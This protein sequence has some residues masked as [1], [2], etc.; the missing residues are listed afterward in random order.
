MKKFLTVLC[1]A[2]LLTLVCGSAL[3]ASTLDSKYLHNTVVIN[4]LTTVNGKTVDTGTPDYIITVE[5]KCVTGTVK[6]KMT[7]GTYE[8][9]SID[10]I[11]NWG[12]KAKDGKDAS[13]EVGG[14]GQYVCKDCGAVKEGEVTIPATGHKFD[15]KV[16]DNAETCSKDG[17]YHMECSY[18]GQAEL[19]S[20]KSGIKYTA[21]PKHTFQPGPIVIERVQTCQQGGIKYTTCVICGEPEWA[22]LGVEKKLDAAYAAKGP[23]TFGEWIVTKPAT[24]TGEDGF[25]SRYCTLCNAEETQII[26][27][28]GE[29]DWD[30]KIVE[31]GKC[32]VTGTDAAVATKDCFSTA[33]RVCKICGKEEELDDAYFSLVG[34]YKHHS[35]VEKEVVVPAGCIDGSDGS[36]ILVCSKCGGLRTESIPK[37]T[38]HNFGSWQVVVKPTATTNGVWER[39]CTNYACTAKENYVGKTAPKGAD[40]V[41]TVKPT[42]TTTPGG[43]ENYKV[44]SWNYNA[45]GVSGQVAGNVSYRTPGLSVNVIIYTPQGTFLAVSSPVDENGQFSVSAGGAVYAVS[46]QLKDNNKTYQTD[47]KYV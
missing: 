17:K 20:D 12:L 15:V 5:P 44:T 9:V 1:L 13:C 18:C 19:T 26:V 33:K 23:H 36:R 8:S 32:K 47:G 4:A 29:H 7:D 3:A 28:V 34:Y 39:Y 45:S 31:N 27:A 30:Y 43:T 41:P 22:V 11:H 14:V 37:A 25:Q 24:C 38:K 6:I 16:I 42:G 21:I 46:I 2:L 10:P 40:P 35:F